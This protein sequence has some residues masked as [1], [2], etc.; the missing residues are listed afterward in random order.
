MGDLFFP[1]LGGQQ[2]EIAIAFTCHGPKF[3]TEIQAIHSGHHPITQDKVGWIF[4]G[5]S[6]SFD[7]RL[8]LADSKA[9]AFQRRAKN[10]SLHAAI[11]NDQDISD[12]RVMLQ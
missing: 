5:S 6:Q 2:N 10:A 7:T 12:R 9:P 8:G 1:T 3:T 11:V 4:T